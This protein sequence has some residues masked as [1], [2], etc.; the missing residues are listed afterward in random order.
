MKK[1]L[2]RILILA[3][4]VWFAGCS[5]F[6]KE[7]EDETRGWTAEKLY[8]EAKA[9]QSANNY[10]ESIKLFEKL[11]ARFPYGRFAQQAQLEIAYSYYKSKEPVLALSAV[12]RFIRQNPAHANLDYAYY[13]RGLI[14]FNDSQGFMSKLFPQDMSERDP[15]AAQ[16]SY[17]AF[18]Q[19]VETFPESRYA[20]DAS[21][22]MGYLIG[23]MAQYELHVARYYYKRGA[24][25]AAANRCKG[26][27]QRYPDTKFAEPALGMMVL[28]YDK[29]GMTTLR[30][31]ARRVLLKNYPK[32]KAINED[33]L[34]DR[35]WWAPV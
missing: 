18:K 10:D 3:C 1:I 17:D 30:D 21:L 35:Y 26:L 2:P 32:S 31:D 8:S 33:F 6:G 13:L 23:A 19:L 16:A 27:L 28:A 5:S 7:P 25:L 11:E 15:K 34:N 9:A 14:Q 20:K 24:F 4:V 29:L 22:R 12:D